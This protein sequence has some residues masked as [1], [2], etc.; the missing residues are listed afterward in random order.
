MLTI[1]KKTFQVAPKRPFITGPALFDHFVGCA[2]AHTS[3][4]TKLTPSTY[5]DV[6][7]SK[8]HQITLDSTAGDLTRGRIIQYSHGEGTLRF[9]KLKYQKTL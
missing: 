8:Y 6:E 7:M 4:H 2:R 5:L 1:K 3:A 9:V